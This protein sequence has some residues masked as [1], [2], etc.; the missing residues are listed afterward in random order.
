[1]PY[2]LRVRLPDV[3]GSLGRVASAIGEA[4]GDIDAIEIVEKS[5][6][7]A[8]D[9]VLLEIPPG[10]MPDSVVS[11]CGVLDGVT[12]L[13]INRYAAGGNLFLDL[14]VVEALTEDPASARERIVDLLPIAFRVDWAARVGRDGSGVHGTELAPQDLEWVEVSSPTRLPG[15]DTYVECVAPFGDDVVMMGRRGGPAF[16]DSELARLSHL[17]GLA[18]TV[19]RA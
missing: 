3:P 14:E 1:M 5:D 15:D 13:W 17:L 4:G 7:Y 2:L 10:T 6:G 11:A 19:N 16:L 18:A 9:D 12:V 8:V